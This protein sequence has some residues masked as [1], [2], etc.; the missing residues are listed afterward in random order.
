MDGNSRLIENEWMSPLE[1]TWLIE[2]AKESETFAEV[3]CWHGVTT[4]NI[5]TSSPKTIVY[6]VDHFSSSPELE[7]ITREHEPDWQ[8]QQFLSNVNG[9]LNVKIVP[10]KSVE[11][12]K[13][14]SNIRFDV[15]FIDAAHD[16][17]SVKADVEAWAPLVKENGILCGHDY[18]WFV[19]N[20]ARDGVTKYVNEMFPSR[21]VVPRT[22]IWYVKRGE[23]TT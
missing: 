14:L 4:R 17:E 9:I 15:V 13:S 8:F 19:K 10:L 22:A 18:G 11:A 3:G 12:A 7:V 5:A 23:W 6:A 1:T 20:G 16:Y 21:R 2:R